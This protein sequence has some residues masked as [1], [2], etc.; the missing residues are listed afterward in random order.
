MTLFLVV[1]VVVLLFLRL[2]L[3]TLVRSVL[4]EFPVSHLGMTVEAIEDTPP[5]SHS[6]FHFH[7]HTLNLYIYRSSCG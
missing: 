3:L 6:H 2:V 4:L 5:H 7:A 1:V